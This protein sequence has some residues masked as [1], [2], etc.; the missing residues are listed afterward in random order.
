M[1]F[2]TEHWLRAHTSNSVGAF[3]L[4]GA[5]NQVLLAALECSVCRFPQA[6][7]EA[8]SRYSL[9][10][11]LGGTNDADHKLLDHL[12][13]KPEPTVGL[14]ACSGF[15]PGVDRIPMGTPSLRVSWISTG[16]VRFQQPPAPPP[17]G[18]LPFMRDDPYAGIGNFFFGTSSAFYLTSVLSPPQDTNVARDHITKSFLAKMFFCFRL[19]CSHLY[20]F[21]PGI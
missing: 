8:F 15:I 20:Q 11:V 18:K 13:Y 9:N 5:L 1:D 14:E 6:A 16:R 17:G 4:A 19:I 10:A 21:A 3:R 2:F 7:D 12:P